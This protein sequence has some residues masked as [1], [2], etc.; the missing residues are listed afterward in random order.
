MYKLQIIEC[1]S[2]RNYPTIKHVS[3]SSRMSKFM[4]EELIKSAAIFNRILGYGL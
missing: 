3:F 2:Y 4:Y 1:I